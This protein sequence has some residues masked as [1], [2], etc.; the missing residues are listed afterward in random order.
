MGILAT[1]LGGSESTCISCTP[2]RQRWPEFFGYD[3]DAL[4][5]RYT[6]NS[7]FNMVPGAAAALD[8][9]CVS[10]IPR[11]RGRIA[12]V[13][14]APYVM[15]PLHLGDHVVGILLKHS[16]YGC[17]SIGI[18]WVRREAEASA[19]TA[20]GPLVGDMAAV[21]AERRAVTQRRSEARQHRAA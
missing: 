5:Y 10:L 7:P 12:S 9:A 13:I 4:C 2:G 11:A 17:G 1:L 14:S 21:E 19:C 15:P 8:H 18:V 16:W 6:A 3:V 20:L